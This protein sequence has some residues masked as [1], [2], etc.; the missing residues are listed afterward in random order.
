MPGFEVKGREGKSTYTRGH[1]VLCFLTPLAQQSEAW[2]SLCN[3]HSRR[4][5][6]DSVDS[7]PAF[8]VVLNSMAISRSKAFDLTVNC[9][10]FEILLKPF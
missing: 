2:G 8:I 3:K 9:S 1:Q 4:L 10:V 5:R 7:C 6:L